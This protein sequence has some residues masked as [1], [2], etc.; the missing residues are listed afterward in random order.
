MPKFV[1]K[2]KRELQ[3]LIKDES[4]Y[5]GDIDVSNITDMTS[6]FEPDVCGAWAGRKDFSGIESWNVSNVRD[7]SLMFHN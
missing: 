1:P 4:I 2:T 5:L 3:E 7:M 6:L